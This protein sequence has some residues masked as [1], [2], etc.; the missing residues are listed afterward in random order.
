[1]RWARKAPAWLHLRSWMSPL[2][3]LR[4]WLETRLSYP[5]FNDLASFCLGGLGSSPSARLLVVLL[6]PWGGGGG[7]TLFV[8]HTE[9]LL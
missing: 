4:C 2:H 9:S 8:N 7:L 1:M 5:A 3:L 6:F